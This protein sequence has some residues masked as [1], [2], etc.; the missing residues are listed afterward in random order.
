MDM[1]EYEQW[2][3]YLQF[4]EFA[5]GMVGLLT[6][7]VLLVVTPGDRDK[8]VKSLGLNDEDVQLDSGGGGGGGGGT[9]QLHSTSGASSKSGK[10][11]K[12]RDGSRKRIQ[13][14]ITDSHAAPNDG[15]QDPRNGDDAPTTTGINGDDDE[16][17]VDSTFS[18]FTLAGLFFLALIVLQLYA[19]SLKMGLT[20]LSNDTDECIPQSDMLG[21]PGNSYY[22][23]GGGGQSPKPTVAAIVKSYENLGRY[24]TSARSAWQLYE[25]EAFDEGFDVTSLRTCEQQNRYSRNKDAN[26]QNALQGAVLELEL[27]E[28]DRKYLEQTLAC[29]SVEKRLQ[30]MDK[31]QDMG[32]EDSKKMIK[33]MQRAHLRQIAL[34]EKGHSI[35]ESFILCFTQKLKGRFKQAL[36]ETHKKMS[37][38]GLDFV[39]TVQE[40]ERDLE[41]IANELSYWFR[42]MRPIALVSR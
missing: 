31:L 26:L 30:L 3:E 8:L 28:N 41:D 21:G 38:D 9:V 14:R 36:V 4:A 34:R 29:H 5:I 12:R 16:N 32:I 37:S 24:Q 25:S 33:D 42:W 20:S 11:D 7:L 1:S 13:Q 15:C 6:C 40:E 22:N 18:S 10:K 35:E 23:G 27:E 2:I 17:N 19:T 39:M